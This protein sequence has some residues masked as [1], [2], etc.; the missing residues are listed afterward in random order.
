MSEDQEFFTSSGSSGASPGESP[1]LNRIT[2]A[3]YKGLSRGQLGGLVLGGL[4][5]LGVGVAAAAVSSA[6]FPVLGLGA[7]GAGLAAAVVGGC[8]AI[9]A[10]YYYDIFKQVGATSGAVAAGMEINEE[11]SQVM[12]IKLDTILNVLAKDGKISSAEIK[13]IEDDVE[14]VYRQG[15]HNFE[16]K[17][18]DKP[19]YYWKIG[20]IG[21]LAGAA[22]L[23]AMGGVG[24][25]ASLFTDHAVDVMGFASAHAGEIAI[26]TA[27][28]ALAGASYGINRNYYRHVLNVT[29]ALFE[30][31]LAE[32]EKQR[33]RQYGLLPEQELPDF[34]AIEQKK[35]TPQNDAHA[36]GTRVSEP[37]VLSQ[38][39][40]AILA[41]QAQGVTSW[42]DAHRARAEAAANPEQ[43]PTLH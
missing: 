43:L 23:A 22:L 41:D 3:S 27:G 1:Y 13:T 32:I 29:N 14:A 24:Y 26:A 25:M 9:G 12:N 15:T 4:I 5:G 37:N 35:A 38:P 21:A 7:M 28:S 6:V 8:T 2:W 30:G 42:Q 20:A 16:K 19:A 11:R 31:N 40:R 33:A 10:H 34:T 18:H 17:F 39:G 36:P